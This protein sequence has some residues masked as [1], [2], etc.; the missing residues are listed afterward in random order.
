VVDPPALVP[1]HEVP[2]TSPCAGSTA[3]DVDRPIMQVIPA[4]H[5]YCK[6]SEVLVSFFGSSPR[7]PPQ[8][9][10]QWITMNKE[11]R[12]QLLRPLAVVKREKLVRNV[13]HTARGAL[14]FGFLLYVTNAGVC[15]HPMTSGFEPS[16]KYKETLNLF[17]PRCIDSPHNSR[18]TCRGRLFSNICLFFRETLRFTGLDSGLD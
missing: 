4:V 7:L 15:G 8:L 6:P 1:V 2:H 18:N 13:V 12:R 11:V 3:V 16:K 10:N 5:T 17:A 9:E 14:M